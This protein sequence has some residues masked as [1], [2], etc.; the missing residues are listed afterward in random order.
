METGIHYKIY[1]PAV[2]YAGQSFWMT[3]EVVG[4]GGG[5]ETGY[6]GIT[7]FTSSDPQAVF[8]DDSYQWKSD[9][10]PANGTPYD[11]GIRLFMNVTLYKL[12]S[13]TIVGLDEMDGSI[14]GLTSVM[15]VGAAVNLTKQPGLALASSGDTVQFRLC[16]SNYSSA[17]AFD[18]TITD[19]V[20]MGTNLVSGMVTDFI[21]GVKG[22]VD[23]D[24]AYSTATSLTA[25]AL[26]SAAS[27]G[28][29][30]T[31]RWLRWTVKDAGIKATGCVCFRVSVF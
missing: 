19:A 10:C 22:D 3:V 1:A 7:D 29:P 15:V 28:I 16:W 6:C 26:F 24:V 21:C 5:I 13:Q 14:T 31:A 23:V 18:L 27:P 20:P 9:A 12:G 4:P 25:P 11:N 17:T 2:A 8:P 30:G